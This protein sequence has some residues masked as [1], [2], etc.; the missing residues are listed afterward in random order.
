MKK[1]SGV[2]NL[3]VLSCS[4]VHD[5][6]P[7]CMVLWKLLP[8]GLGQ[9]LWYCIAVSGELAFVSDP[10]MARILLASGTETPEPTQYYQQ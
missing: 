9:M 6:I 2:P 1:I 3:R 4:A 7:L 10:G 8:G 5:V